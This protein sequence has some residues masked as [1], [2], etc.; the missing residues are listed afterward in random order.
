[1]PSANVGVILK[2]HAR[3][4]VSA[5]LPTIGTLLLSWPITQK[6]QSKEKDENA[7]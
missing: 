1:M 3:L 6:D 5:C 2:T 4:E 7:E